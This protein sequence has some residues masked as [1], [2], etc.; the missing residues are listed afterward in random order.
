MVFMRVVS[1]LGSRFET[2]EDAG[3]LSATFPSKRFMAAVLALVTYSAS[4]HV[5][6]DGITGPSSGAPG[7]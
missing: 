1:F 5:R 6:R 7:Y 3:D 2:T 4:Y